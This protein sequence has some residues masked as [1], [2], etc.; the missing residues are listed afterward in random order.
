MTETER[1][2][3]LSESLE[4]YHRR[5][6]L[7]EDPAPSTYRERLGA[8]YADF[9]EVLEASTAI[10]EALEPPFAP[11]LPRAFGPYILER[12]LGRGSSGVVYEAFHR[13]LARRV[14]IKVLRTAFD[15]DPQ[16][17]EWFR[18]EARTCAQVR[19]P[20]IVQVYEA[21]EIE[22]RLYYTMER[23]EGRTL[24]DLVARGEGPDLPRLFAGMA[25]VA[26]ALDALHR[27]GI[28]HR[29]VKPSNILLQPD[30]RMVL[31]D[32][33]LARTVGRSSLTRTGQTV[34]TPQYMSPEQMLGRQ[35]QVDA[36]SD[37]Y[38]LGATLYEAMTGRLPFQTDELAALVRMVLFQRPEPPRQLDP[39]IP[40]AAEA[41]V[42]KALEKRRED[43][44]AHAADLRDDLRAFAV[45]GTTVGRP[46]SRRRRFV[47]RARRYAPAIIAA[48]LLI[49][50]VVWW[51]AT[52]PATILLREESNLVVQ[53]DGVLLKRLAE[54]PE[55]PFDKVLSTAP[56]VRMR[57]SADTAAGSFEVE[58]PRGDH[59]VTYLLKRPA[60]AEGAVE[61]TQEVHL[62]PG[63]RTR[64]PV[65]SAVA[66][67]D[68]DGSVAFD[69]LLALY[70]IQLGDWSQDLSVDRGMPAAVEC[71]FPRGD[72]RRADLRRYRCEVS[73]RFSGEHAT[74]WFR[75]VGDAHDLVPA[76]P[77]HPARSLAV[78]PIPAEVLSRIEVGDTVAWGVAD[79]DRREPQATFHVVEKP[80]VDLRLARIERDAAF[81]APEV[82]VTLRAYA[83][84]EGGL[85]GAAAA[86]V[87]DEWPRDSRVGFAASHLALQA[88]TALGLPRGLATTQR[89]HS[90]LQS[91]AGSEIYN[92]TFGI[93]DDAVVPR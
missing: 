93:T 89:V 42:L 63:V 21:G 81:L 62:A 48:S 11:A 27:A 67:K 16:A 59:R 85:R 45:G 43:R 61:L 68:L 84:Y 65:V 12:E 66:P 19:H 10:D 7:G 9:V 70:G 83:L 4:D 80:E 49:G 87:L 32:F 26:D 1:D 14:A 78:E 71:V 24:A 13:P 37:I 54:M 64:A 17:L 35:D 40:R 31:A 90:Q 47:R 72:L 20:S 2:A 51:R 77:F 6:A 75:R 44:Y 28:V 3:R 82:R 60:P 18:R 73:P 92:R 69:F 58:V 50:A 79:G 86:E 15:T 25:D 33:G 29:D 52:R 38:A 8:A 55:G 56:S 34:G 91:Y 88:L 36:R 46:V 5:Q 22:G 57:R 41:V 53:V 76:T 30:G 39:T 23:L 74:L